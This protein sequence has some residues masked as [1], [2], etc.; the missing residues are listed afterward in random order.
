VS[1]RPAA[2]RRDGICFS[3]SAD[4]PA[5]V[6]TTVA[7]SAVCGT[8]DGFLAAVRTALGAGCGGVAT[9]ACFFGT[10]AGRMAFW[11]AGFVGGAL[12]SATLGGVIVSGSGEAFADEPVSGD[13]VSDDPASDAPAGA[14]EELSVVAVGVTAG[15]V[16]LLPRNAK[17]ATTAA[18]NS[19]PTMNGIRLVGAGTWSSCSK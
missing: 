14:V 5:L 9:G 18:N 3:Q 12:D 8:G 10:T 19:P 1:P 15:V 6:S 11:G 7:S 2:R 17:N 13:P 16:L 4:A